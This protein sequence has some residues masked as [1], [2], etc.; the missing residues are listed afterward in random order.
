MNETA[1][2]YGN[3]GGSKRKPPVAAIFII[4][5]MAAIGIYGYFSVSDT[6]KS[7]QLIATAYE[8]IKA[9]NYKEGIDVLTKVI[10]TDPQNAD[11][12]MLRAITYGK[13]GNHELAIAGLDKAI[14]LNRQ[15]TEAYINRGVAYASIAKHNEAIADYYK[16]IQLNPQQSLVYS[17]RARS[18]IA[19]GSLDKAIDDYMKVVELNPNDPSGYFNVSCAYSLAKDTSKSCE[20]L[21]KSIELGLS[22]FREVKQD[23]DLDNIRDSSCYKKIM[24]GK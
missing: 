4:V 16:A 5:A 7:G 24:E 23:K 14:S 13:Q 3:T 1:A 17:A 21:Q 6:N 9:D 11:A 20:Y 12:H 10:E 22:S 18:Y 2:D 19:I 8:A 15:L